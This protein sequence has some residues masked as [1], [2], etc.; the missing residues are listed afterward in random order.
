MS[1][2]QIASASVVLELDDSKFKKSISTLQSRVEKQMA[3][4]TKSTLKLQ[5]SFNRVAQGIDKVGKTAERFGKTLLA[6]STAAA[7]LSIKKFFDSDIN[8]RLTNQFKEVYRSID[9]SRAKIG[10]YI[11]QSNIFGRSVLDWFKK[12]DSI[13]KNVTQE[14]VQKFIDGLS[15]ALIILTSIAL[16]AKGIKFASEVGK[17]VNDLKAF[18]AELTKVFAARAA[19]GAAGAIVGET[20]GSFAAKALPGAVG[21]GAGSVLSGTIAKGA[22]AAAEKIS[23]AFKSKTG[24]GGI[25][26]YMNFI[27]SDPSGVAKNIYKIE[28]EKIINSIKSNFGFKLSGGAP[29]LIGSGTPSTAVSTVTSIPPKIPFLFTKF[30]LIL[31]NIGNVVKA[32]LAD[33]LIFTVAIESWSRVIKDMPAFIKELGLYFSEL[34]DTLKPLFTKISEG[35][36]WISVGFN[37]F[38]DA[39]SDLGG[40]LINLVNVDMRA[41]QEGLKNFWNRVTGKGVK[42]EI[43]GLSEKEKENI[44]IAS[45]VKAGEDEES[46]LSIFSNISFL[47]KDMLVGNNG[48]LSAVEEFARLGAKEIEKIKKTVDSSYSM[49]NQA[50]SE[51][52][53]LESKNKDIYKSINEQQ[54]SFNAIMKDLSGKIESRQTG[55]ISDITSLPNTF[56]QFNSGMNQ[57]LESR[58]KEKIKLQQE[59]NKIM[60][61]LHSS[62]NSN[63]KQQFLLIERQNMLLETVQKYLNPSA[64]IQLTF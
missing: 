63:V 17:F 50:E 11:L 40:A 15:K 31:K 7:A 16:I 44:K 47:V 23:K 9:Q 36:N 8:P 54:L 22:T 24:A 14:G 56:S 64:N 53:D 2:N 3:Q 12:I 46:P 57:E 39:I 13:L 52:A 4:A 5:A 1:E 30:G 20:A 10:Q 29:T 34:G 35:F 27:K 42:E 58:E 38:I 21:V 37:T 33:F 18:G 51:Y 55:Q 6:V 32:T 26:S 49:F 28:M 41:A 62:L 48:I 25:P 19:G 45:R 43:P 61:D 60:L 59:N